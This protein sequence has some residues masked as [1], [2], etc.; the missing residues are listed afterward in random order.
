MPVDIAN[1]VDAAGVDQ[2]SGEVVLT[3]ADQLPWDGAAHLQLLQ[4]K[5][6]RYLGFIEGGELLTHYPDAVGRSM[7]I[8]VV[9]RF[10]PPPSAIEFLVKAQRTVEGY[11]ST[12]SWRVYA[13]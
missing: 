2:T 8:D 10:E 7:R 12:F 1:V 9:C 3:I 13:A 11:G 4:E 6:N 5:L